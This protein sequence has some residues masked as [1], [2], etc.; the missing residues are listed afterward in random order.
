[1]TSSLRIHQR[2]V[3]FLDNWCRRLDASQRKPPYLYRVLN[4]AQILGHPL[5]HNKRVE[6]LYRIA[7]WQ[8]KS[9]LQR[10]I[11][12]PWIANQKLVVQRGMMGATGNIYVGLIEFTDM[13]FLLHFLRRGDLFFDIG[14]NVGTYTV[15]ASGVC[16]AK[17]WAFEPDKDAL[18]ALNR[19]IAINNLQDFVRVHDMAVGDSD[20]QVA[21]TSGLGTQNRVAHTGD[22]DCRSVQQ[23]RIDS[24]IGDA[25]PAFAKLDIE[26]RE[27]QALRGGKSLLKRVQAIS[28]ETISPWTLDALSEHGFRRIFYDPF[29][30]SLS[31]E[32]MG[33]PFANA[34]FVKDFEIVKKRVA[35]ASKITIFG[36]PI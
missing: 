18:E 3:G 31:T 7:H 30:R 21:F 8:I 17:T 34:L 14:A 15:L 1:M 29:I 4:I 6:T 33:F 10:E 28:L 16:G 12:F 25:W 32:P 2:L 22:I 24:V 5:A 19:N 11:I 36:R 13:M 35:S 26:K 27:E 20:Q 23:M 9:R